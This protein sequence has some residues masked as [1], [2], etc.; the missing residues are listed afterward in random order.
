MSERFVSWHVALRSAIELPYDP[1]RQASL[2][3]EWRYDLSPSK[4][5]IDAD[6]MSE[7]ERIWFHAAGRGVDPSMDLRADIELLFGGRELW[8]WITEDRFL[9]NDLAARWGI[10]AAY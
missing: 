10:R 6:L 4:R 7:R 2:L 3:D 5:L 8:W 1:A 9:V